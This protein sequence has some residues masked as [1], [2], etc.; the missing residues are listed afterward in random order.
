MHD[1]RSVFRRPTVGL[2]GGHTERG[3]YKGGSPVQLRE[4][5]DINA[6]WLVRTTA[7][8]FTVHK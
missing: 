7:V 2:G 8:G 4:S 1:L 5:A 6:S 3:N